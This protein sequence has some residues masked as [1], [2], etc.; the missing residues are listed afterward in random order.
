MLREQATTS[1]E[2]DLEEVIYIYR[3]RELV[4]SLL[5]CFLAADMLL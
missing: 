1:R 4:N 3:E 5:T 2:T